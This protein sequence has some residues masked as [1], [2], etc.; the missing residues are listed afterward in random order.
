MHF[1]NYDAYNLT[2]V[3]MEQLF[4]NNIKKLCHVV[5]YL[6]IANNIN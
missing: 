3:Q 1:V 5:L 4:Q 6:N 2:F